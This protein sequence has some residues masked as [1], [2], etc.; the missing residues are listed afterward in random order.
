MSWHKIKMS[1]HQ[2][3]CGEH[4][5]L[6]EEFHNI[7]NTLNTPDDMAL[8]SGILYRSNAFNIYFTPACASNSSMKELMDHWGAISCVE[9]TPETERKLEILVGD[10]DIWHDYI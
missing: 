10:A 4:A 1:A 3:V 8:L 7:W 6:Q 2:K 9:P 5:K